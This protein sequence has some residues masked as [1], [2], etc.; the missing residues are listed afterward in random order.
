[1]SDGD[2]ALNGPGQPAASRSSGEGLCEPWEETEPGD[3]LEPAPE[4]DLLWDVFEPYDQPDE[5]Q[6]DRGDFWPQGE[7]EEH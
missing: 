6:P 3:D 4:W 7:D 2:R 5:P 1:M